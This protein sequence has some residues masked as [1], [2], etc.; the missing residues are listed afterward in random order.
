M[1]HKLVFALT[2]FSKKSIHYKIVFSISG[3]LIDLQGHTLKTF[4]KYIRRHQLLC[5]LPLVSKNTEFISQLR[6]RVKVS[7]CT[8]L[9][10]QVPWPIAWQPKGE[11]G[12]KLR[13]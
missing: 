11:G 3:L 5:S 8:S 6:I 13:L 1:I 2:C 9:A 10:N 12:S 4:F 7:K